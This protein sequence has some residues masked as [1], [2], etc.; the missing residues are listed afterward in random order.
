M[1]R[2]G[3]TPPG[4]RFA[5][6]VA[7]LLESGLPPPAFEHPVEIEGQHYYLDLAWPDHMVAVECLGKIG[8]DYEKA[9]ENDPVRRNRMGL[10]GWLVLEVT[11]NRL[12]HQPHAVVAEVRQ[13]LC[14]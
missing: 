12:V 5:R 9:F 6:R 7:V 13:S 3:E 2:D 10:A 14:G 8:H 1:A 4:T 11:W